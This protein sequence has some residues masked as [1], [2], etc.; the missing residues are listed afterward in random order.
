MPIASASKI[1]QIAQGLDPRKAILA[2]I[3]DLD[4]IDVYSDLVL[5]GVFI[6]PEK[7]AGGIYR[8]KENIQEDEYQGKVGLVLKCGP[9]AFGDWEDP[10]ER[11]DMAEVGAWVVFAIKDGWPVQLNGVPC[12][13]VPYDKLR[14]RVANP[15]M[16]TSGAR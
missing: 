11:G 15:M 9:L 7:T 16:E 3:G 6:R 14:A 4:G 1:E 2:A 10:A 12:R 5:V 13:F 8:P